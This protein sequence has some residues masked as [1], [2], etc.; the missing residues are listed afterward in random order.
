MGTASLGWSCLVLGSAW[1]GCEE[2]GPPLASVVRRSESA[3]TVAPA[4]LTFMVL[5]RQDATLATD[6]KRER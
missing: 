2:A 4:L 6:K 5:T 1:I 3:M